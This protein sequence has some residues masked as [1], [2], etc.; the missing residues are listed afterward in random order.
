M[1]YA[2]HLPSV[3][4]MYMYTSLL[5]DVMIRNSYVCNIKYITAYAN[6]YTTRPHIGNKDTP[7][8]CVT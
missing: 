1:Y 7:L 5:K 2:F 8:F 3:I 4:K 6:Q